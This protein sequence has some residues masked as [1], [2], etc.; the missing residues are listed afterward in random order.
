MVLWALHS[1]KST[2]VLEEDQQLLTKNIISFNGK[3]PGISTDELYSLARPKP[4]QKFVGIARIKLYAYY[5]GTKGKPDSKFRKWLREKAGE[6]P[7]I[8]DSMAVLGSAR[9]MEL[10]LNKIGY[11]YSKVDVNKIPGKGRKVN[12]EYVITLTK[13][14]HLKSVQYAI[15]DT[16][17]ARFV[18][19]SKSSPNIK[20]G[21]IYN[22]FKLDDERDRV[23]GILQNNGYYY[24]NR[25]F[26]YYEIDSSLK[27][28]EM[29]LSLKIRPNKVVSPGD[30]TF[31]ISQPHK[32]YFVRNIYIRPNFD[33]IQSQA[34]QYDTTVFSFKYS[35]HSTKFSDYSIVHKGDIK[36]HPS[37]ISQAVFIKPGDPFCLEDVKKTRSRINE[38]GI[39]GYSNIRFREI[40]TPDTSITGLLDC[41]I[42]LLRKKL[43]SFTIETEL[44]NSGGQPGIGVNFTYQNINIFK[45]A[46]ILRLKARVA[47]EAQQ[48][49]GN[50][51]DYSSTVPFFSTIQ[52]GLQVSVDFPRFLVPIKQERFPKYFR[53]KTTLS[54]GFGYEDRPEYIRWVINGMFGYDWKESERKRHQVFPIDWS[55]VNVTLS[56][57]FQ[58]QID[59]EPNNR[60][61]DQ[62]TDN[63]IMGTKYVFTYSTQNLQKIQNFFF[64]KGNLQTAGNFLQAGYAIAQPPKDSAGNYQMWGIEYAQFFKIDGDF[65]LFRVMSKNTSMAYRFFVGLGIPYGN[66]Q[67]MPIETGY[68]GGGSNDMRGWLYRL[69]GP[70]SYDNPSDNYDKMGDIQLECN[71][72]YRFPVYRF[73]KS[74]LFLDVGNIW[75]I[76]DAQDYPGGDFQFNRFYKEFAIDG[77]VGVRLDF[78]FFILRVDFAI[79]FRNPAEPEGQRW[80]FDQ[81]QWKDFIINFGIGYPF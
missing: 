67:V 66:S 22:A 6:R 31:L 79:P 48:M 37:T 33:P 49:F 36:V 4:N 38:L 30:P 57:E 72:E 28:K 74:A 58:Q 18:S 19:K 73:I 16:M 25:D 54:L 64:F 23:T 17:I 65:R 9:D 77:G 44:T 39:F 63:V 7:A 45:G 41:N 13:P 60:I 11:F 29:N 1:C 76:N 8:Y 81:W 68:Y 51:A 2:K 3:N 47:L 34:I 71:A 61:K 20:D 43:H 52:T 5:K 42:D 40:P 15:E 75:V 56:P 70:G 46:E 27:N 69:L 50:G 62:Y 59:T 14:Y 10:Y 32:R 35:K 53:P 80:V 21:D 24:F 12:M 26:I 78:N 55:L